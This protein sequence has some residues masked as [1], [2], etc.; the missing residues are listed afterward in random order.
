MLMCLV[1]LIIKNMFNNE[2]N[3]N[4][5]VIENITGPDNNST[6]I[7]SKTIVESKG[8]GNPIFVLLILLFSMILTSSKKT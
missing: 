7:P 1:I 2:D 6:I 3:I 4:I 5:T 8:T